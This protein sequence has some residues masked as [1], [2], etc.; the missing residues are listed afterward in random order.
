MQLFLLKFL[1]HSILSCNYER[2]IWTSKESDNRASEKHRDYKTATC[3]KNWVQKQDMPFWNVLRKF[4][5]YELLRVSKS[6]NKNYLY[7]N[8]TRRRESKTLESSR[9]FSWH[10]TVQPYLFPIISITV[11]QNFSNFYSFATCT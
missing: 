2:W 8:L 1:H 7:T 4:L 10:K 3:S 9:K 6:D 11:N 5:I